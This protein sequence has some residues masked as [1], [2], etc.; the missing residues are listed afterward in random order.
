MNNSKQIERSITRLS[1]REKAYHVYMAIQNKQL[2]GMSFNT[3]TEMNG[4]R[5]RMN[6]YRWMRKFPGGYPYFPQEE[7]PSADEDD[8][9][10][11]M[12]LVH[13]EKEQLEAEAVDLDAVNIGDGGAAT[14]EYYG[15]KIMVDRSNIIDVLSAI[16]CVSRKG[17]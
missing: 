5:N 15:A 4:I 9:E 2:Y 7:S 12:E 14:I 1:D 13:I 8:Q 10:I 6:L 3:Y 17:L 16:R 11:P